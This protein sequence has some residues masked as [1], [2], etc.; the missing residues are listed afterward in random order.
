MKRRVIF[1]VLLGL[2]LAGCAYMQ[3]LPLFE[4][5]VS[6]SVGIAPRSVEIVA[7]QRGGGLY[8]FEV[9]VCDSLC[10][11]AESECCSPQGCICPPE[12][13]IDEEPCLNPVLIMAWS[14]EENEATKT[15]TQFPCYVKVTWQGDNQTEQASSQVLR[16]TSALPIIHWPRV[17]GV[18]PHYNGLWIQVLARSLFDFNFY[19][20][21][22]HF[23][24]DIQQKFGIEVPEGMGYR[25]TDVVVT[26]IDDEGIERDVSVYVPP[27]VPGVYHASITPGSRNVVEN[28]FVLYPPY[29]G[30]YHKK[31]GMMQCP[32]IEW[33]Y[34][35]NPCS[36]IKLPYS[37]PGKLIVHIEVM[38]D[39]CALATRDFE[40]LLGATGCA[41]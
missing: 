11:E 32:M 5:H 13:P 25:I 35:W 9:Y 29:L 15:F 27:Y 30:K 24:G 26:W 7:T 8:Y 10:E 12:E 39:G 3:P 31:S 19:Q 22:P 41:K 33:T 20:A 37:Q 16:I 28:A 2:F 18:S 17:N 38:T 14:Q 23:P 4:I 1:L 34:Y 36:N 21:E 40:F 6:P